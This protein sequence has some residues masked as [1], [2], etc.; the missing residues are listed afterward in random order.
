MTDQPTVPQPR[1]VL[2]QSGVLLGHAP[3]TSGLLAPAADNAWRVRAA[4]SVRA[5]GCSVLIDAV[6]DAGAAIELTSTRYPA[7]DLEGALILAHRIARAHGCAEAEIEVLPS[8]DRDALPDLATIM[9]M[10]AHVP[11]RSAFLA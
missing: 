1:D 8:P 3:H 4:I 9:A 2:A 7:V 11:S 6:R 10:T 5:I